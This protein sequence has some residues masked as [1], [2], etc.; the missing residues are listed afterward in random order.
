LLG[1]RRDWQHVDAGGAVDL[2][3]RQH[4]PVDERAAIGHAR[5]L[6]EDALHLTDRVA[7]EHRRPMLDT[8]ALPPVEDLR[9]HC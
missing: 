4:H 7:E 8:V 6:G 2:D 9:N 5:E 3:H 1:R